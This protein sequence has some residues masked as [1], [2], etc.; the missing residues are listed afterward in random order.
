MSSPSS[1]DHVKGQYRV[2]IGQRIKKVGNTFERK[3]RRGFELV[4][5]LIN[6]DIHTTSRVMFTIYNN[7]IMGRNNWEL[8]IELKE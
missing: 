4:L 5:E 1:K 3:G 7:C 6:G 2:R 8:F